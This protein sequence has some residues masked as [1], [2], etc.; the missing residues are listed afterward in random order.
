MGKII[1]FVLNPVAGV[2]WRVGLKGSDC[3]V[4]EAFRRGGGEVSSGRAAWF[5]PGF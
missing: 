4:E 3:V 2:G 5:F 1:G